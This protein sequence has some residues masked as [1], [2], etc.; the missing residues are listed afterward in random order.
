M[1]PEPYLISPPLLNAMACG[2]VAVTVN[3]RLARALK[4]QYDQQQVDAGKIV[5]TAPHILPWDA[6]LNQL[7]QQ[8]RYIENSPHQLLNNAQSLCLWEQILSE[9]AT[10]E[11]L[12]NVTAAA[13]LAQSAWTVSH[14][15]KVNVAHAHLSQD[16]LTYTRWA[17]VYRQRCE[18][19]HWLDS[20]TL[21]DWLVARVALAKSLPE[22][23][24]ILG[25]DTLPCAHRRL[26]DALQA[27]GVHIVIDDLPG[28]DNPQA[29]VMPCEDQQRENLAA[30]NWARAQLEQNDT[31]KIGLVVPDLA[32]RRAQ[33][34]PVLAQTFDPGSALNPAVQISS[35][36]NVSLGIPLNEYPLVGDAL[37]WLGLICRPQSTDRYTQLVLSPYLGLSESQRL[38]CAKVNVVRLIRGDSFSLHTLARVLRQS[39]HCP[40]DFCTRLA[41]LIVLCDTLAPQQSYAAWSRSFEALLACLGWPGESGLSSEEFQ[42]HG[43]WQ[44]TLQALAGFDTVGSPCSLA[45]ALSRLNTLARGNVFQAESHNDARLQVVGLLEMTGMHFDALWVMGMDDQHWPPR[46]VLNPLLPVVAQRS[47]NV[48]HNSARWETGFA[49]R[50]MR[51]LLDSARRVVFSY[52]ASEGG[53]THRPESIDCR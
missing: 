22:T 34:L 51:R 4:E 27:Q 31:H 47:A 53:C 5:W 13:T 32:T 37:R 3:R 45:D 11:P 8:W 40:D 24:L 14:H 46:P 50:S 1:L 9:S 19:N 43:A 35:H 28:A 36:Y 33:L 2:A 6:W 16:Q 15:W 18:R 44:Q 21:I 39:A 12:L 30:V 29:V 7:F 10:A 41:A 42:V 25:F 20:A 17:G 23:L 38:Q 26:L 48:P 49:Q 52:A